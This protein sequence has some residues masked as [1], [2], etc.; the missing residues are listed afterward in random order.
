MT[1]PKPSKVFRHIYGWIKAAIIAGETPFLVVFIIGLYIPFEDFFLKWLPIPENIRSVLRFA[2]E[3]LLYGMV[4]KTLVVRFFKTRNLKSTP[5][6]ILLLFFLISCI[7]S[8]VINESRLFESILNLRIL[9]RYLSVFYILVNTKVSI[10][11]IKLVLRSIK[12]VGLIQAA[13]ASL[14]YFM[15]SSFQKIFAPTSFQLGEFEKSSAAQEGL[16]KAG[17]AFGTYDQPDVLASLLLLVFV[18]FLSCFLTIP[19]SFIDKLQEILGLILLVF[20]IFSSKKRVALALAILCTLVI[21]ILKKKLRLALKLG[22]LYFACMLFLALSFFFLSVN[23]DTSFTGADSY[24]EAVDPSSYFLQIFSSDYYQHSTERAR[25]WVIK[26]I[27]PVL[28]KSG[29]WFGFGPDLD[30]ARLIIFDLLNNGADRAYILELG[31]I[32]DV[33]WVAM[34]AYY[35]P[36]GVSIYGLILWRLFQSGRWLIRF[37]SEPE[38]K[39]LGASFCTFIIFLVFYHFVSRIILMRPF[40]YHFWLFAGLVINVRG[41]YQLRKATNSMYVNSSSNLNN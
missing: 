29:S 36:I 17:S 18:V 16:N 21:L 38:H 32:E 23:V 33:Y 35:G 31:P 26:T 10:S 14:Q 27:I 37:S 41:S 8:I 9:W 6:D 34:L 5:I 20:G 28:F 3:M 19:G 2:P 7:F 25:G 12:I 40:G 11:Q 1:I 39:I 24:K 4:I 30:N 13:L 22:W 15:P